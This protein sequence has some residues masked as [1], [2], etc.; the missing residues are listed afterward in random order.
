MITVFSIVG[1]TASGKSEL[2]LELSSKLNGE[3]IS[4]DSVQIYKYFDIGSAK[5]TKEEQKIVSHHLIDILEPNEQCTAGL[6]KEKA[7]TIIED[8]HQRG[9]LPIIVGGT[10][11]YLKSLFLG[12]F[13]QESRNE[14][15]RV[16]LNQRL[17]QEGS[18][19][20]YKELQSIDPVYASKISCEDHIRIVRALEAIFVTKIKFSELHQHNTKPNWQWIFSQPNQNREIIYQNIEKRVHHMLEKGL[21]DET[22]AIIERFGDTSPVFKTIGYR[23]VLNY[24]QNVYDLDNMTKQLILDTKHFAKRQQTLFRSLLQEQK[25]YSKE[26]LLEGKFYANI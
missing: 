7:I 22:K 8:I 21:I 20:L 5:P 23:H 4:C 26:E 6:W 9:K 3:I 14:E 25:I 10:G 2:A 24:L 16:F 12:M 17:Q 11:L 18:H 15:Y 1:A 19:I 13:E